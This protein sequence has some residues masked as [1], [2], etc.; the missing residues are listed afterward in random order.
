MGK[1]INFKRDERIAPAQREYLRDFSTSAGLQIQG[2]ATR[3]GLRVDEED[4]PIEVSAVLIRSPKCGSASGYRIAVNRN[5]SLERRRLSI[6]HEIG[7]FVLHRNDPEFSAVEESE[8][9]SV[10]L[11]LFSEIGNSFRSE[12]WAAPQNP[13]LEREANHFAACLL[14]PAHLIKR[15]VNYRL[16]APANLAREFVVSLPAMQVRLAE[17]DEERLH[18]KATSAA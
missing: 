17:I 1:V 2:L 5:H 12:W 9:Y 10:V 8:D 16:R 18:F 4:L 15:S 6:A 13:R 3:L 7:H 11:P 14:M